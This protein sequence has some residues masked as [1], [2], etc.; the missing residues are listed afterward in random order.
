MNCQNFENILADL[1]RDI[2]MDA[3]ARENALA[4]TRDCAP[5]AARLAAE[6]ALSTCLR[7]AFALDTTNEA[8]QASPRVESAL[9]A[10]FR[11]RHAAAV[12]TGAL[13]NMT[14]IAAAS[15][16]T[17]QASSPP[18]PHTS[19]TTRADAPASIQAHVAAKSRGA[20]RQSS[21][22]RFAA[23]VA[24]TVV[25]AA[26]ATLFA[27]R[28]SQHDEPLEIAEQTRRQEMNVAASSPVVE[29]DAQT[30]ESPEINTAMT[31]GGGQSIIN[32]DAAGLIQEK[33]EDE[34]DEMRPAWPRAA[35][36][37]TTNARQNNAGY[38]NAGLNSAGSAT[39]GRVN[40]AAGG[41]DGSAAASSNQS[42]TEIAT[43]FFPLAGAMTLMQTDSGH[44]VRV[45]LPRSALAS[46][47]LQVN[48]ERSTERVKADVLFGDDG[49]ARAIRFVR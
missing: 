47:G 10:A 14:P 15:S 19:H 7:R 43:D 38:S 8:E 28:L 49:I 42:E 17:T 16:E 41:R 3:V 25:V 37:R 5:C 13:Q 45:E 4:H 48:A 32:P 21:F 11:E 24:A 35:P 12:R 44:I 46:F 1:A 31:T 22:W 2:M 9:L 30:F 40:P 36:P 6:R 29:T 34:P 23:A 33:A 20:A 39:G 18:A 27:A 26:L